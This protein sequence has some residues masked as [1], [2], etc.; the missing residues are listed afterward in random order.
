MSRPASDSPKE[1]IPPHERQSGWD[2]YEL[3]EGARHLDQAEKI[4][5]NKPFLEAIRKHSEKRA[6]E[7]H[8]TAYR[9]GMLARAG[10]ISPKA[11]AKMKESQE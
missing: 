1:Y 6:K 3:A 11:M 9:A 5:Q 7:H 2:D 8:A 10:H 4:A